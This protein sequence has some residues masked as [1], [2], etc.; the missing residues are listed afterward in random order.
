MLTAVRPL[1]LT[2]TLACVKLAAQ[3]SDPMAPASGF[4]ITT[5]T[6]QLL[7][8]TDGYRTRADVYRPTTA[9]G[10]CG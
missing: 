6:N 9:P 8:Y 5:A 3:C 2:I 1:A 4:A 10:P 7:T